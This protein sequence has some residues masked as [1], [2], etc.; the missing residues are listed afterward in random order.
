[1]SQP[2]PTWYTVTHNVLEALYYLSGIALAVLAGFGL[3]QIRIASEQ[4]KFT[5]EIVEANKRRESVKLAAELCTYF[6]ESVVPSQTKLGMDCAQFNIQGF[7]VPQQPP[8]FV[9]RDGEIVQVNVNLSVLQSEWSKI[10]MAAVTYLNN[11]ESFAIPFAAGV[12]DGE[13]GFQETASAFCLGI[14]QT[15]PALALL[16]QMQNVPYH[17][18]LTLYCIWSNR[19]AAERVAPAL[20]SMQDIVQTADKDKNKIK[21][22]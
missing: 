15:L 18:T 6:A 10:G 16:K 4:L 3:R 17:S 20:K 7:R 14:S 1:M 13:I 5:K 12:A 19:L 21:P 8:P 11:A 22:L 9:V 2:D